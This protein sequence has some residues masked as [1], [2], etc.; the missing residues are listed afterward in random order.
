MK[1]IFGIMVGL[2]WS[3]MSF[4]APA[5]YFGETLGGGN[6]SRLVS[7]PEATAARNDFLSNLIAV[8]SES[9]ESFADNTRTPISLNFSGIDSAILSGAGRVVS[10]LPG[11]TNGLGRFATDGD[12]Y[13]QASQGFKIDFDSPVSAFGF[14]GID[15]GDHDGQ[16]KLTLIT[17]SG[18]SE[19]ITVNSIP[20]APGGSV[21]FWGIIDNE[22]AFKSIIFENTAAGT[23]TFGFD[24]MTIGTPV[25][26]PE[27]YALLL[28]GLGLVSFITYRRKDTLAVTV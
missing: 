25:P 14:M 21:L 15:I 22:N 26:E 18:S 13:W 11:M 7:F 9:F 5:I 27:I 10:T 8:G 1:K 17:T 19:I 3:Q 20:D 24:Q 16:V 6:N 23:D 12:K 2:V 4:A 28:A